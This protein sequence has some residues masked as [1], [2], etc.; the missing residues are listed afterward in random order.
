MGALLSLE[1]AAINSL[2]IIVGAT[3][4]AVGIFAYFSDTRHLTCED[5]LKHDKDLDKCQGRLNLAWWGQISMIILGA[6][7]VL[8]GIGAFTLMSVNLTKM[9]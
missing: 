2:L 4:V 9:F 7:L 5:V 3:A 1:K 8:I 6:V